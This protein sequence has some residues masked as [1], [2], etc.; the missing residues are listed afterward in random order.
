MVSELWSDLPPELTIR[1][2]YHNADDVATLRAM[3]LVSRAMRDVATEP[4]FSVVRFACQEDFTDWLDMLRETPSLVMAVRKVKVSVSL[5]GPPMLPTLPN[6]EEVEWARKGKDIWSTEFAAMY[7]R[8]VFSGATRLSLVDV[9]FGDL[10]ELSSLLLSCNL[11]NSLTICR[12]TNLS[13]GTAPHLPGAPTVDLSQLHELTL[14]AHSDARVQ[15]PHSLRLLLQR[16]QPTQLRVLKLLSE[17]DFV[18][19][20]ADD[21]RNPCSVATIITLLRFAAPSLTH[22]TINPSFSD[23]YVNPLFNSTTTRFPPFVSLV[24]FALHLGRLGE[25]SFHAESFFAALNPIPQLSTLRFVSRVYGTER[26]DYKWFISLF[27]WKSTELS[28]DALRARFPSLQ[29]V[30]WAFRVAPYAYGHTAT[31]TAICTREYRIEME[32][33]L[34]L[35]LEELGMGDLNEVAS[36]LRVEWLDGEYRPFML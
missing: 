17:R 15:N 24:E 13:L 1:I 12:S 26:D 31:A 11:L 30:V 23:R 32:R 19:L 27:C 14:I 16:S 28:G 22:L 36:L 4:L 2:A 8:R 9:Q 34:V 33:R 18:D 5:Q 35:R 3:R 20:G 7:M 29:K 6:V 21:A 10:T 25:D